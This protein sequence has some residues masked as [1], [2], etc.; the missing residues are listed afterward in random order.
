M[1]TASTRS[2]T[3]CV[4]NWA[5][6]LAT[7]VPRFSLFQWSATNRSDWEQSFQK[8]SLNTRRHRDISQCLRVLS[9]YLL[10]RG[11]DEKTILFPERFA[12]SNCCH[13]G[14]FVFVWKW[15]RTAQ[16]SR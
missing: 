10:I 9:T 11:K 5:R 7:N 3:W 13:A 2:L 1:M 16:L 14:L 15:H 8:E 12:C 6:L 4:R